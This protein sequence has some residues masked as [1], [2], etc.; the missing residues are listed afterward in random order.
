VFFLLHRKMRNDLLRFTFIDD[1]PRLVAA[2]KGVQTMLYYGLS[3]SIFF[4]SFSQM[5]FC[6][7]ARYIAPTKKLSRCVVEVIRSLDPK[8]YNLEF[9]EL[10]KN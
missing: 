2:H 6:E 9:D 4:Y 1:I 10:T 3:L 5:I 8:E 7:I